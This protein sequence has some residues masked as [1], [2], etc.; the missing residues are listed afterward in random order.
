[1]GVCV[2]QTLAQ[3]GINL[4]VPQP[5]KANALDETQQAALRS[6]VE[7]CKAEMFG[8]GNPQ[9]SASPTPSASATAQPSATPAPSVSIVATPLPDTGAS[10]IPTPSSTAGSATQ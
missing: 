9:P 10:A 3:Q 6:A 4:P 5:G 8:Q 7:S 2:G 1:M